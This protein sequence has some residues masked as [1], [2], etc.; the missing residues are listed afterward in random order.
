MERNYVTV[1]LRI[2]GGPTS[3]SEHQGVRPCA[4]PKA[5]LGWAWKGIGSGSETDMSRVGHEGCREVVGK[6]L[7][8]LKYVNGI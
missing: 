5:V 2:L 1:T 4:R 6:R 8:F 7:N 3:K